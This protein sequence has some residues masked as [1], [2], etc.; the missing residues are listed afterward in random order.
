MVVYQ[1]VGMNEDGP[2]TL[3]CHELSIFHGS[4]SLITTKEGRA[5]CNGARALDKVGK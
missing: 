3:E 4:I 1:M 5:N 2:K